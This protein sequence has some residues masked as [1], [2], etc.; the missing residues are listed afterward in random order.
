MNWT[1]KFEFRSRPQC[2]FCGAT[3]FQKIAAADSLTILRCSCGYVFMEP[4]LTEQGSQQ[5]FSSPITDNFPWLKRY[6]LSSYPAGRKPRIISNYENSLNWLSRIIPGRPSLLDIGCGAGE[7]LSLAVKRGWVASGIDFDECSIKKIRDTLQIPVFHGSLEQMPANS[8]S[9]DVVTMWDYFEHVEK[10][11]ETLRRARNLLKPGGFL[12]IACPNHNG[13]L[14]A[15]ARF[16]QRLRG[17]RN[18]H[19]FEML[20]PP[21]HLS[22]FDSGFLKKVASSEGFSCARMEYEETDLERVE[23]KKFVK[24]G[25]RV[26]FAFARLFRASNR[27]TLYLKKG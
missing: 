20:Y 21:T 13:W 7:F 15:L 12:V 8:E 9:Y 4:H 24:L 23:M 26:F 5:V 3:R 19:A 2:D 17:G 22:Y 11:L 27:F 16:F 6:D 10:P 25:L 18:S 14:F 1:D